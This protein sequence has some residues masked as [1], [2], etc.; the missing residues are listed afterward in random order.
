M[1]IDDDEE[2][3]AAM[4]C[5][6][7]FV[8]VWKTADTD[9]ENEQIEAYYNNPAQCHVF[10]E[11]DNPKKPRYAAKTW[12]DEDDHQRITLYYPDRLEYYVSRSKAGQVK[13]GKG[14]IPAEPP[15]APNPWGTIPVFHLRKERRADGKSEL[16]NVTPVQDAINK[17][18]A[19]M[20]IAAEFG[21]FKQRYIISNAENLGQFKNAPNE[22]WDL[23]AGD[24]QG[25]GTQVGEFGETN[26]SNYLSAIKDHVLSLAASPARPSIISWARAVI[27]A[28]RR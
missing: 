3:R 27:R 18:L 2:I 10:Y 17:L 15:S 8:I 23:P 13:N 19:D 7:S 22:I 25:Q 1:N 9:G 16:H 21:A 11:T 5:P 12:I 14:F 4:V 24:G 20:M 26:L 6:E 28:A